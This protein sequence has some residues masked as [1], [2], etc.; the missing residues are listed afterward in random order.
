MPS[1]KP[2]SD[3]R[4]SLRPPVIGAVITLGIYLLSRY[5]YLLFHTTAEGFSI[6]V[7]GAAFI[8]AWNSWAFN[9]NGYLKVLGIAQLFIGMLDLVHTLAYKGM[10]V[11]PGY[12]T[13]LPTQLWIVARYIQALSFVIAPSLLDREINRQRVL[14]L[15]AAV[16]AILTGLIFARRFPA[17]Y[18]EG[19]GLTSF[20]IAS[21]IVVALMLAASIVR[22]TR[23]RSAFDPDVFRWIV[24]ALG[25]TIVSELTFTLYIDVYGPVNFLGHTLK[26][27]AF[28]YLYRAILETGLRRPYALLFH[29]LDKRNKALEA[30]IVKHERAKRALH[31]SE[32]RMR[33]ILTHT[34]AIIYLKDMQG[35]FTMVNRAFETAFNIT[36]AEVVGKTAYDLVPEAMAAAHQAHDELVM[37][38]GKPLQVEE[39]AIEADGQQHTALSIKF[40]MY[41]AQGAINGVG[42]I[43]ADITARKQAEAALQANEVKYRIVSELVSDYAYAFDVQPDGAFVGDWV[44]GAFQRI[45]GYAREDL[46]TGEDWAKLIH[47]EDTD[48]VAAYLASL[49]SGEPGDLTYRI[50]TK[51]GDI[52][53]LHTHDRPVWDEEQGRVVQIVGA[54]QD[55]TQ[56]RRAEQ[57][58][59]R[60][61]A[62]FH[63]LFAS[64]PI[65]TFIW[66]HEDGDFRLIDCNAAVDRM[67]S[68]KAS[69]F[70]GMTAMQIYPDRPDILAKFQ[71]CLDEKRVLIYETDYHTRGTQ[72][73]RIIIFTFV[74]ID[75]D[76]IMLHSEDITERKH[77][78]QTLAE[79]AERLRLQHQIDQ[80]ILAAHS[81]YE[82]ATAVLG[83]LNNLIPCR[84]TSITE[85][86]LAHHQGRDMALAHDG[87]VQA[88]NDQWHNLSIIGEDMLRH[89]RQGRTYVVPDIVERSA[90]TFLE[91]RL[92][93]HNIRAYTSVPIIVQDELMGALNLAGDHPHFVQPDHIAILEEIADSLAV[94]LQQARL[95]EQTREDAETKA[96]LLREVN[97]RVKNNLDAIMGLLYIERRHAPP[98]A[99]DAYQPVMAE[100]THRITGLAQVHH[101]LSEVEWAPLN[102]GDL[103]EQIIRTTTG[104]ARDQT[105]VILDVSPTPIHVSPAQ[106]HHLALILNE[107]TTNTL[108]H[109]VAGRPTVRITVRIN[110]DGDAIILTYHNDGPAY[111]E[112]V[113][114]LER[115]N[116]GLDIVQ[117]TV[118]RSLRGRLTLR[119]DHGAVTE[120]QF[121]KEGSDDA[122]PH[123]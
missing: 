29:N 122:I 32:S 82:I 111:P 47:P 55:I 114:R 43:S 88:A 26:I 19:Q 42:G 68:G 21:E 14:A 95:L 60:S 74:Y 92:V 105:N 22:I 24:T 123:R 28:Y 23:L 99:V 40:P 10:G 96:L 49:K 35:R 97:H 11:F 41:D 76:I 4:K 93:A 71:T 121:S 54:V 45:T 79:S 1:K 15:Y 53:W 57:A 106:A 100:L 115:H 39:S 89:I 59:K 33:A 65:P 44:I 30:Q 90:P 16:T 118:R 13:N 61:E 27:W 70:L 31:Q 77:I 20:K 84:Q 119:N 17:C 83:H 36:Q 8:I 48:K 116:A 67:T 2:L 56:R 98:E 37:E 94:A 50:I 38:T 66:E 102:L 104:S 6:L 62:R 91:Q 73:N 69:P 78:A 81:S 113:L 107:L 117:Q 52:R 120:I 25:L 63:K 58:L 34:P 75:N 64:T 112:E 72:L 80:A 109:G 7:A 9:Q 3:V 103:A 108:K 5:N 46:P 51:A 18:I 101:M 12:D 85:I 86:D 87:I 110:S